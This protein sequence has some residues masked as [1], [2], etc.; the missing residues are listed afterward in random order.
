MRELTATNIAQVDSNYLHEVVLVKLDFDEPV[1]AHSG[2]GNIAFEANT[3][4]G[5]GDFG[6]ISETKESELLAPTPLTLELS[7]INDLLLTE[8]LD[9]GTY[10]DVVTVF[11]GFRQDDGTLY[12]DP[13]VHWKGWFE[14]ASIESGDQNKITVTAQHDLTSLEE[15][16]GSRY[17]DEDQKQRQAADDGLEFVTAMSTLKLVW[18][19]GNTVSI[20]GRRNPTPFRGGGDRR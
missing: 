3:Y 13:L 11:L 8:S 18:G 1:Y 16:D 12:D 9:A 4:V 10:R 6:G 14:T 5:V 17:S 7:A 15:V 2:Y 20:S 19:G